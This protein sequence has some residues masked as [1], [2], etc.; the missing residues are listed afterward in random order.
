MSKSSSSA[1]QEHLDKLQEDYV[2]RAEQT[3]KNT[4]LT[5]VAVLTILLIIA[6][7]IGIQIYNKYVTDKTDDAKNLYYAEIGVLVFS[8]I[9]AVGGLLYMYNKHSVEQ[10]RGTVT[11][12]TNTY[13]MRSIR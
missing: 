2:K 6:A 9:V 12:P 7:S 5:Q 11:K 10:K 1:S 13:E 8:I 3:I 4:A